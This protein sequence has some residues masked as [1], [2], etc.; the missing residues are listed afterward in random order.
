VSV[1]RTSAPAIKPVS[2][3]L[4]EL[5]LVATHVLGEKCASPAVTLVKSGVELPAQ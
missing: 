1:C 3:M 4:L 2:K 5:N